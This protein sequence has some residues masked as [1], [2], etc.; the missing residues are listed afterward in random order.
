MERVFI[1][2]WRLKR[3]HV[4]ELRNR[5]ACTRPPSGQT[6][7]VTLI[8]EFGIMPFKLMPSWIG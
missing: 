5:V 3:V 4:T 1:G 2:A 7:S 8:P 6:S